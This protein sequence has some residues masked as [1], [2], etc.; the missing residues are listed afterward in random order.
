MPHKVLLLGATG[1]LGFA[2]KNYAEF[3]NLYSPTRNEL[4]LNDFKKIQEYLELHNF[5]LVINCTGY[6]AVDAAESDYEN[7][8]Y[9]NCLVPEFIAKTLFVINPNAKMIQFSSDYVFDG[10]NSDGYLEDSPKN[11]LSKYGLS[12]STGEDLVL[13]ANPSSYIVRVSWLFGPGKA[14]FVEKIITKYRNSEKIT[15]VDDQFGK[16]TY[17]LDV[18]KSLK[19]VIC[20]KP[21]IYHLPSEGIASWYELAKNALSK[22]DSNSEIQSCK[23][24]DL[25]S[26]ATRP[27]YSILINS[28][29]P[30]SPSYDVGLTDYLT[31]YI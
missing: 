27:K 12:K 28:K 15:V 1:L 21:G 7:C 5:E 6:N 24:E 31:N 13:E 19:S 9:L 8:Y 10:K 16:P 22:Y 30:E 29:L 20:G 18:A 17:T 3:E 26:F 2:I 23:T 25:N 11:P 4:N 14:N